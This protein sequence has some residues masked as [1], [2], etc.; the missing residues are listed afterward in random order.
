MKSL[1]VRRMLSWT[2]QLWLRNTM[3]S[4]QLVGGNELIVLSRLEYYNIY[5][6][7]LMEP[8]WVWG[9]ERKREER[10]RGKGREKREGE[11][12]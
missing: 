4:H 12:L 2:V 10:E 3:S 5:L 7:L 11:D 1:F 6:T 9:G 8:I